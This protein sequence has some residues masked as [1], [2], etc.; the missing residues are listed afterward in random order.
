[1]TALL[2]LK[3]ILVPAL[4][5][6][7]TLAGRRWGPAVAGWLSGFPVVT[8]PI[9]LFIGIEQGATFASATAVGALAGGIA[10][11][12][13]ALGYAWAAT[14][15]NWALALATALACWLV[16]GLVLVYTAPPFAWIVALI[17]LSIVCV[18]F[19]FPRIGEPGGVKKTSHAELASR[20]A[21][22]G[23][24]TLLVTRLSPLLGPDFSG[25]FAVFPVMGI[26]LAAFSHRASG[27]PYTIRLLRGMVAGFYAFTSFCLGVALAVPRLGV[28]GGFAVALAFSLAV[29]CCTLWAMRR[30]RQRALA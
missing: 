18:P 17:V 20:M 30:G 2:F 25:L 10:W 16:A 29:H 26:V 1:M 3:L 8:G 14:K 22:G 12:G 11:V 6:G 13:F 15:M 19:L 4:I 23:L 7:I 5:G 28:A 9:L 27:M 24:M 21:A